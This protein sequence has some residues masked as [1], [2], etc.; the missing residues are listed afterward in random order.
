MMKLKISETISKWVETELDLPFMIFEDLIPNEEQDGACIR[1][2]PTAAAEK[3]FSDG[4]R[5]VSWNFTFYL[6]CK[7]PENA[8]EIGKQIIDRLDGAEIESTD[9]IRIDCEAVTLPQYID[10]DA[11]GY[12]TYSASIRCSY[13]EEET[14]GKSSTQ[15]KSS[16]FFEHK[17]KGKS[18]MDTNK[19]INIVHVVNE[20]TNKNF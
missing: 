2:D 14:N 5:L 9:K 18:R 4:T 17:N 16:S 6:R 15:D 10:T 20:P 3:R 7:N 12:T 11:K 1:H 19:K 13:L 8:R